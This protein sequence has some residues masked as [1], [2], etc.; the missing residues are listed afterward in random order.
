MTKVSEIARRFFS[1]YCRSVGAIELAKC[2]DREI[3]NKYSFQH[4]PM[5]NSLPD[6]AVLSVVG[7]RHVDFSE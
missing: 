2:L 3:R 4:H 7:I 5:G 1:S 6:G